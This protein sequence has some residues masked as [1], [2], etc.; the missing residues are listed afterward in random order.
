MLTSSGTIVGLAQLAL[1]AVGFA[2]IFA[3][4]GCAYFAYLYF[5]EKNRNQVLVDNLLRANERHVEKFV[6]IVAESAEAD[7]RVA[8]AISQLTAVITDIRGRFDA[9]S[10]QPA[11]SSRR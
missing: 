5:Q 3:L 6:T 2:G 10:L 1:D 7:N 4:V 9:L 11:R 8:L